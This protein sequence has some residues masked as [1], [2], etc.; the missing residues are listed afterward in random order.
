MKNT[1][2]MILKVLVR[3]KAYNKIKNNTVIIWTIIVDNGAI[4]FGN[5]AILEMA[6]LRVQTQNAKGHQKNIYTDINSLSGQRSD[7]WKSSKSI[8]MTSVDTIWF[9]I[10]SAR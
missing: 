1:K 2:Q 4:S 9:L 5:I 10:I 8:F 6:D 7:I 3:K